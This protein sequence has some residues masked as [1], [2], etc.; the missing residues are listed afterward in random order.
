MRVVTRH[1]R[2][3][4]DADP[5]LSDLWVE[6]EVSNLSRAASGH[7]YFTLKD[8]SAALRCAFFRNRQAG[9]GDRLGE[10]LAMV[11]HGA[12]SLYEP[13]G[14]LS[15]VVDFVQP[16][17]TGA[18]AAEF[19]RR[20]AA[21]E[22]EGLFAPERKRPLPRFPERIGV[23]TS[24]TGAVLHDITDVLAR[25]WPLADIWLQPTAVQGN[26][27]APR[28]AAAIGALAARDPE[29]IIVARGGGSAEDLWAFNEEP[30]VRAIF[31]CPVPVISAVGHETDTTLADLVA[32]LRAP[33]PSAAAELVAPDRATVLHRVDAMRSSAEVR[34]T[35]LLAER[36]EGIDLTVAGLARR[37]PDT[38]ALRERVARH[39]RAA[40]RG[41][42]AALALAAERTGALSARLA[43]LSPLAT[44]ERG[45]AIVERPDG[46]PATSAAA[47]ATGEAVTLRLSDG[48]RPARIEADR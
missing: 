16:E 24:P 26:D 8:G 6:G 47:L 31:G 25:R 40:V 5:M 43:V 17:G 30:V 2:G 14:D 1:L 18:L 11:V 27:A 38:A 12:L 37:M 20:R 29:V 41:G 33:T 35:R 7:I 15:L 13:R 34:L 3:V 39:R 48:T 32:D 23:V 44:L 22:A 46:T 42:G 21:L 4:L 36:Q 45:Y 28:I 10:G 19:E 9:Q